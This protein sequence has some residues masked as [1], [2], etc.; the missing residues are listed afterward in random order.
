MKNI[1]YILLLLPFLLAACGTSKKV[2]QADVN[3]NQLTAEQLVSTLESK[4]LSDEYL[5]AK[6]NFRFKSGDQDLSVGG[7]LKMKKNDVIQLSLVALGIMEAARIE[8][9]PQDVLVIDR[10]NKRY[11]KA[12]YSEFSFLKEAGIDYNILESLFRNAIFSPENHTGFTLGEVAG[13]NATVE[14][15]NKRLKFR[16]VTSLATSLIQQTQISSAGNGKGEFNWIYGDFSAFSDKTFPLSHQIKL[17]GIGRDTEISIQLKNIG[18]DSKWEP[19]TAV[20]N[21]YKE[22]QASDILKMLRF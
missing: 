22:M 8:F 9:T 14:C 18:N 1:S 5:T 17:S 21:S 12:S 4:A 7:H 20:K 10:L 2:T 11:I 6:M 13:G 15:R 3:P 16:F 19:H